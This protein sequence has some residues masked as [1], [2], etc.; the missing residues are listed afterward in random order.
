MLATQSVST[1]L[2]RSKISAEGSPAVEKV[3]GVHL[4]GNQISLTMAHGAIWLCECSGEII[5]AAKLIEALVA[6]FIADLS[7]TLTPPH[8]LS[9]PSPHCS[10]YILAFTL[11]YIHFFM[12]ATQLLCF[13]LLIYEIQSAPRRVLADRSLANILRKSVLQLVSLREEVRRVRALGPEF[14]DRSPRLPELFDVETT[15]T[16][17]RA[18]SAGN[19]PSALAYNLM[20]EDRLGKRRRTRTTSGSGIGVGQSLHEALILDEVKPALHNASAP[21]RGR[22]TDRSSSQ[23]HRSTLQTMTPSS[24]ISDPFNVDTPR[25]SVT[26]PSGIDYS[27]DEFVLSPVNT[28]STVI[29]HGPPSPTLLSPVPRPYPFSP[30]SRYSRWSTDSAEDVVSTPRTPRKSLKD[31]TATPTL[32]LYGAQNPFCTPTEDRIVMPSH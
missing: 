30:D 12:L 15:A 21:K 10:T 26:S 2:Q 16:L 14:F 25:L 31:A 22:P 6:V 8:T 29:L 9:C 23:C 19:L 13:A 27:D 7:S 17:R 18:E 1:W 5:V 28:K 24:D 20:L 11:S 3:K 4:S 32:G